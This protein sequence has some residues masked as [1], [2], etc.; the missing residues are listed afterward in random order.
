MRQAINSKKQMKA[1]KRD[2]KFWLIEGLNPDWMDLHDS[3]D[4]NGSLVALK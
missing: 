4:F 3:I 2:W 1:W